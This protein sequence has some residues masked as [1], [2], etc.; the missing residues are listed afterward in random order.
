MKCGCI[1]STQCSAKE[2]GCWELALA[3]CL[4]NLMDAAVT[5]TCRLPPAAGAELTTP[6]H[7]RRD[8]MGPAPTI[9]HLIWPALLSTTPLASIVFLSVRGSDFFLDQTLPATRAQPPRPPA[10]PAQFHLETSGRATC[11]KT[12]GRPRERSSAQLV[13]RETTRPKRHPLPQPPICLHH[14]ESACSS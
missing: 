4:V 3:F 10:Q 6:R 1:H 9:A 8:A 5:A 12:D 7:H 13:S 14:A 2:L 11:N